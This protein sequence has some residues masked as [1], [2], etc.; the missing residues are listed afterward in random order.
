MNKFYFAI[1]AITLYGDFVLKRF[2]PFKWALA[3]L[4]MLAVIIL[5]GII[6]T[7]RDEVIPKPS[8]T[9]AHINFFVY[10]LIIIY[11]IRSL[12][13]FDVPFLYSLTHMLYICIPLLYIPIV[14]RYCAEFELKKMINIFL[15]LM[16]PINLAGLIQYTSNPGFL[17]STAYSETGGII[18]RS[19]YRGIFL[20]YP[21]IFASAD[22]YSAIGLIQ[23]YFA[24]ILLSLSENKTRKTYLWIYFNLIS[25]VVAMVI[26]GARTRIF[27]FL[28]LVT[29]MVLSAFLKSLFVSR[30]TVSKLAFAV[31]IASAAVVLVFAFNPDSTKVVTEA[32]FV[33]FFISSVRQGDVQNRVGR[34]IGRTLLSDDISLLGEGLGSLGKKGK[35]AEMGIE[36]IWIECG[37]I[38]GS[39]ILVGFCGMIFILVSLSFQAFIRGRPLEICIFGLPALALLTGLLTGL[40]SV[41][42]FSSGIPLMCATGAVIKQLHRENAKMPY[43]VPYRQSP[44][45]KQALGGA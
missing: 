38:G 40:T 24:I 7:N 26:A 13:S 17:I 39:L 14:S 21:S 16:I 3:S 8:S 10:Y 31:L 28:A 36:S 30:K 45:L 9:E 6:L 37:F 41:F 34:Y 32:P 15:L 27:I 2:L 42:E 23:F 1:P 20:R 18:H 4:Y 29:L 11:C 33:R 25:S 12:T 44:N 22:R 19:V 5:V 43:A 35:P